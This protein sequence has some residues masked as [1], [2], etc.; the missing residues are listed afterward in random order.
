[1]DA[2]TVTQIV[3]SVGFPIACCIVLIFFVKYVIE[4]FLSAVSDMNAKIMLM[5][6]KHEEEMKTIKEALVGNTMAIREMNVTLTG[7]IQRGMDDG[8]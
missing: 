2:N 5:Q 3:S 6:E 8:K 1:M 7:L 4:K